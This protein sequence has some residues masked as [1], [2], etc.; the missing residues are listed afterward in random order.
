MK[1]VDSIALIAI[2][3]MERVLSENGKSLFDAVPDFGERIGEADAEDFLGVAER[4]LGRNYCYITDVILEGDTAA[5]N[6]LDLAIAGLIYPELIAALKHETVFGITVRNSYLMNGIKTPKYNRLMNTCRLVSRILYVDTKADPSFDVPLI[7]DRELLDYLCEAEA[8]DEESV[9]TTKKTDKTLIGLMKDGHNVRLVGDNNIILLQCRSCARRLGKKTIVCD[10]SELTSSNLWKA[11][12]RAGRKALLNED[13]LCFVGIGHENLKRL[14]VTYNEL[15]ANGIAVWEQA[16][17]LICMCL[18]DAGAA[19]YTLADSALHY[20]NSPDRK[21]YN[22]LL[23]EKS[24]FLKCG[25]EVSLRRMIMSESQEIPNGELIEPPVWMSF[26]QL[27]L[28]EDKKEILIKICNHVWYEDK[29]YKEWNMDSHYFYGKG[30][31]AIFAGPPGT[32]KTMAAYCIANKLN[33]PLYKIDLSQVSDKYIG[34][35][36]KHL[37]NIFDYAQK[38]NVVLFFDEADALFGKRSEVKEAKDRYANTEIAYILQRIE[39]YDGVVLLATNLENNIDTAFIRRIKYVV[40]FTEP[41]EKQR[42]MIWAN[43]LSDKVPS[44][45]LDIAYLAGGFKL[46]GGNIK[47]VIQNALFMAAAEDSKLS[48]RHILEAVRDEFSKYG[49]F[50]ELSE[51]GEYAK[52]LRK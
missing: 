9:F 26:E 45:D 42:Y 49:R 24:R 29:V 25:D 16:G 27:V 52:L 7:A 17:V 30:V 10:L 47:S 39:Q 2:L 36:E 44:E 40:R 50:M 28:P 12:F 21:S 51:F 22:E 46:S 38:Y 3:R 5:N 31:S 48:M 8:R 43:S 35:T 23:L 13:V 20:I 6:A 19:R 11:V 18:D 14:G 15:Y 4:R 34:E 41:D 32:G 37:K 33:M 1:L